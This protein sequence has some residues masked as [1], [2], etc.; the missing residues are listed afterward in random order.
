VPIDGFLRIRYHQRVPLRPSVVVTDITTPSRLRSLPGQ[1]YV[2][3]NELHFQADEAFTPGATI[4]VRYSVVGAAGFDLFTFRTDGGGRRGSEQPP[5]FAGVSELA[6][7]RNGPTDLCGEPE[8]VQVTVSYPS[9]DDNGW[10]ATE[11]E[12]VVYQTRGPNIAGPVERS[13]ELG[14]RTPSETCP[15]E[16]ALCQRFRLAA[17]NASGPVCFNVQA[18]DAYGR[19]D[20]N[21]REVCTDPSIGNFFNGCTAAPTSPARPGRPRW[22]GAA[23]VALLAVAIAWLVRSGRRPR[24]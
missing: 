15:P 3:S 24:G 1:L 19:A 11:T 21:T 10:P 8:A 5:R 14:R 7:Q 20:G 18:V 6:H 4:E 23:A 16:G 9:A 13:R 12:Y 17:R 2:V 22:L